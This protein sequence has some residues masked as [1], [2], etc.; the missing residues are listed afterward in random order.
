[1][2]EFNPDEYEV[3]EQIT[4]REAGERM[5]RGEVVQHCSYCRYLPLYGFQSFQGGAWITCQLSLSGTEKIYYSLRKKRVAL[6]NADSMMRMLDGRICYG[7]KRGGYYF[8]AR[9]DSFILR[10]NG[11]NT[12]IQVFNLPMPLYAEPPEPKQKERRKVDAGTLLTSG[13]LWCGDVPLR[14]VEFSR[15]AMLSN[16]TTSGTLT[17]WFEGNGRRRFLDSLYLDSPETP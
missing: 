4:P 15:E 6:T 13:Q 1:M 14:I 8:D 12:P 9:M 3:D 5:L 7:A 16:A 2:T 11:S 10:D 17:L